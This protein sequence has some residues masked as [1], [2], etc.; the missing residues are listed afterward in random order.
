M[1]QNTEPVESGLDVKKMSSVRSKKA[2]IDSLTFFALN[3]SSG[4]GASVGSQ[5]SG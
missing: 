4:R 2:V 5:L 3:I 1:R